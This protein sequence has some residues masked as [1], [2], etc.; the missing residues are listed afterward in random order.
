MSLSILCFSLFAGAGYWSQTP[1]QLLVCRVL[2]GLGVGGMWPTGVALASEAWSDVSRPLLAGFL[3]ASANVGIVIFNTIAYRYPVTP[4]SWRWTLLLCGTPVLLGLWAWFAVPESTS[5][6]ATRTESKEGTNK[7]STWDV[8]RPPLLKLTI[9]GIL[10][11]TIPLFGGWG[12]TQWL[13]MWTEQVQK[14]DPSAKAL[15]AI[16]RAAGGTI[17]SLIGGWLA[18]LMGRRATYFAISLISLALGEFVYLVM[19]P[20]YPGWS[21]CVFGVGFVTTIFFGWLPLYLPELFPTHARAL[22]SGISFNF[23]RILTAAGVLGAGWITTQLGGNFGSAGSITMLIYAVGMIVILFAPDT[24]RR[25][26]T[27]S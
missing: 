22:G 1:E 21:F 24:T 27:P 13:I 17:G 19:K 25:S 7:L 12:A 20:D 6:L 8:F 15:T 18:S 2:S 10:V 23:G 5:W 3:G 9:V 4:D 11:G 16:M 26:A 14:A